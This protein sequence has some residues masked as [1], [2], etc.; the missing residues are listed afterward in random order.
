M[1]KVSS[2]ARIVSLKLVYYGASGVGKS[3]N[4]EK[5]RSRT[6]DGRSGELIT[7][8][9]EGDP[10]LMF[11][12]TPVRA[13]HGSSFDVRLQVY[14]LPG[15]PRQEST[16]RRL[17]RDADGIVFVLDSGPD[18]LAENRTAWAELGEHLAALGT[19]R[20]KIPLVIQLNKRDLPNAM[21]SDDLRARLGMTGFPI[22]EAV[23]KG[24]AGV[25]MT[26]LDIT[27]R[28]LR[29][30]ADSDHSEALDSTEI[31][32]LDN[33]ALPE[34]FAACGLLP[35]RGRS[36]PVAAEEVQVF[37]VHRNHDSPPPPKEATKGETPKG[38]MPKGEMPTQRLQA[39]KLVAAMSREQANA[40][41]STRGGGGAGVTKPVG[42]PA[43]VIETPPGAFSP[44]SPR[45]TTADRKTVSPPPTATTNDEAEEKL[46]HMVA[47]S[48]ARV[49]RKLAQVEEHITDLRALLT[50]VAEQVRRVSTAPPE[51]EQRVI[52]LVRDALGQMELSATLKAK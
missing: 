23:A 25:G 2:S 17:L 50:N 24:S 10:T 1:G 15:R 46:R 26:L 4:L 40:P 14:T 19:S 29:S 51:S 11:D 35:K 41:A 6:A 7:L 49:M 44:P 28:A 8:D 22:A 3:T 43:I 20:E 21:H 13:G 36:A 34:A 33:V 12:W 16:K 30:L 52:R 39:A 45:L 47:E 5:L 42:R 27:K 38:E 31:S 37:A 18:K 9:H 32:R 48:E